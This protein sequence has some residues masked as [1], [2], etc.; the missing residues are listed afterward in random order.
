M[1]AASIDPY[2]TYHNFLMHQSIKEKTKE[3]NICQNQ[4]LTE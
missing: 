2:P 3:Q 1:K 4:D